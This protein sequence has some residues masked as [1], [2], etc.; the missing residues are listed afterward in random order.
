MKT[1][2]LLASLT[3]LHAQTPMPPYGAPISLELAKK[4]ASAAQAEARKNDWGIVVSIVDYGGDLVLLERMDNAQLGSVAVSQDKAK[5]AV[6]FRRPTKAFQDNLAAGGEGLRMLKVQGAIPV[7]GGL[8]ILVDGKVIGGIGIS[9][10]TSA[11][12]GQMAQAGLAA[13]AGQ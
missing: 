10:A 6:E 5:S 8:P 11:Q 13:V 9:G 7:E 2:L 4:V 1:L 3:C 12:D